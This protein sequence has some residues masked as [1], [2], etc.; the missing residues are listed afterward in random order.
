[1]LLLVCTPFVWAR[2]V[3]DFWE[4]VKELDNNT[5]WQHSENGDVIKTNPEFLSASMMGSFVITYTVLNSVNVV[6]SDLRFWF[7]ELGGVQKS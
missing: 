2:T 3:N 7:M 5:G 4:W 6:I 1:M